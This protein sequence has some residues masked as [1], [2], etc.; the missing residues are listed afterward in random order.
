M[1][2]PELELVLIW[3][4]GIAGGGLA[5]YTTAPTPIARGGWSTSPQHQPHG[6]V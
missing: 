2:K 5:H 1:K 3:D 4:K 6:E